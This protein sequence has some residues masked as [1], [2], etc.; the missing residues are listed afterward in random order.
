MRQDSLGLTIPDSHRFAKHKP[1]T[2]S[3]FSDILQISEKN[4]NINSKIREKYSIRKHTIIPLD[5]HKK[6]LQLL[7]FLMIIFIIAS[8]GY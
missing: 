3:K 2:I 5:G 1:G 8:L 4:K 7:R 6:A